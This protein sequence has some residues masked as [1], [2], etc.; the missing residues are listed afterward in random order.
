M[1]P[2]VRNWQEGSGDV[3][4]EADVRVQVTKDQAWVWPV[5]LFGDTAPALRGYTLSC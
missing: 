4:A 5:A 2:A 1:L 3:S